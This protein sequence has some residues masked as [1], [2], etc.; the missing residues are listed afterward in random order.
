[1]LASSSLYLYLGMLLYAIIGG[2]WGEQRESLE[3]KYLKSS[4]LLW[5]MQ[6]KLPCDIGSTKILAYLNSPV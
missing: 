6:A 2:T 3:N 5:E 4:V 1:M